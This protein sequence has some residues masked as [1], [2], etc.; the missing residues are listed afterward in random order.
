MLLL[1]KLIKVLIK[2]K[3]L[4]KLNTIPLLSE[5]DYITYKGAVTLFLTKSA[6]DRSDP[7][8]QYSQKLIEKIHEDITKYNN[9]SNSKYRNELMLKIYLKRN[10]LNKKLIKYLIKENKSF[11]LNSESDI[12]TIR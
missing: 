6:I 2:V 9:L 10:K 7:L 1:I 3:Q 4:I 5:G 8:F 12:S 11:Y